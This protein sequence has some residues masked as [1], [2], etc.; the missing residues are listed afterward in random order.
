MN[1]REAG[2][3]T[4]ETP[5]D[6]FLDHIVK[7]YLMTDQFKT[8]LIGHQSPFGQQELCKFFQSPLVAD[9]LRYA[10][11]YECEP[12]NW[13]ASV[14]VSAIPNA[15]DRTIHDLRNEAHLFLT[16]GKRNVFAHGSTDEVTKIQQKLDVLNRYL[17]RVI[18]HASESH[19]IY[20][21]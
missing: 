13:R 20:Q 9:R 12:E 7:T 11:E 19:T 15:V 5:F 8:Y 2:P 10:W 3:I 4:R 21:S 18:P 14:P 16:E 17:S 1:A 6:Q